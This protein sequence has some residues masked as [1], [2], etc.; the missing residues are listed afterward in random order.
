MGDVRHVLGLGEKSACTSG[1]SQGLGQDPAV[2]PA[3]PWVPQPMEVPLLS[4]PS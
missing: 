4:V 1:L 2:W 3:F